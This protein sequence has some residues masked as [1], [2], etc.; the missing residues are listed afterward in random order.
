L[1]NMSSERS[2]NSGGDISG[3]AA[4]ASCN[5]KES[6]GEAHLSVMEE[7]GISDI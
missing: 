5:S 7:D 1:T 6:V 2:R 3:H 4:Q